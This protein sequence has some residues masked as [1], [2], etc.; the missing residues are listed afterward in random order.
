MLSSLVRPQ[1]VM[2]TLVEGSVTVTN[3][4]RAF[5]ATALPMYLRLCFESACKARSY[6]GYFAALTNFKTA[7]SCPITVGA[8]SV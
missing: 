1:S 6:V 3:P 2:M 5:E 8:Y 7:T 4:I